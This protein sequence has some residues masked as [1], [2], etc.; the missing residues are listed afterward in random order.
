MTTALHVLGTLLHSMGKLS[1]NLM[2]MERER[3][4]EVPSFTKVVGALRLEIDPSRIYIK[5]ATNFKIFDGNGIS[6]TLISRG[7]PIPVM[8]GNKHVNFK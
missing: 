7:Y 6:R 3:L 4:R 5:Y 1:T 8:T 2:I